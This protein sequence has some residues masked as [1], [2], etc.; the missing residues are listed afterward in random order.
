MPQIIITTTRIPRTKSL[1]KTIRCVSI[2][3]RQKKENEYRNWQ[4]PRLF[5]Y[6]PITNNTREIE[7][8]TVEDPDVKI[9][10]VVK[11]LASENIRTLQMS[12]DGYTFE[13]EYRS[14]GNLMTEL[15]GGAGRSRSHYILRKES[16]KIKIPKSTAGYYYN[17]RFIG[18]IVNDQEEINDQ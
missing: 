10:E 11:E 6:N 12:P 15:F 17:P 14:N 1:L 18:W 7:L 4:I 8:P 13:Y 5:V 3:S 16:T 9:N 2:I